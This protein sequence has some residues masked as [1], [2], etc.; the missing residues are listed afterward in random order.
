MY[1]NYFG[2]EEPPFSIAPN[3]RY[4]YLSKQHR[5]ALAHLLYGI[6]ND[7][8]FVLLTGEVGTGKTT[9][10]RALLDQLPESTDVALILNP[11]YS[12]QE[13][14]ASICDELGIIYP[15]EENRIKQYIDALNQHLLQSHAEG[16]HTVLILDEAQ[17]LGVDVLEQ[18]R[19][20][21]NLETD[22]H[23]LLQIVLVGQPELLEKLLRPELRQLSQ[24][25]TARFHLGALSR[26]ELEAYISHRLEVA[27]VQGRLFP[28][29]TLNRLYKMTRGVPRLI[30]ILCDRALLGAF[31]ERHNRVEVNVLNRAASEVLGED[32]ASV[33]D[34]LAGRWQF[35]G[36]TVVVLLLLSWL[37]VPGVKDQTLQWGGSL[38]GDSLLVQERE[39]TS[40]ATRQYAVLA[41]G[42]NDGAAVAGSVPS[43]LG[44]W[45]WPDRQEYQL[46]QIFAY[47]SLFEA[48][49]IEYNPKQNPVVCKFARS[50]GYA[51][52]FGS[53]ELESLIRLN[54][55]AVLKLVNEKGEDFFAALISIDGDRADIII[56]DR[57]LKVS[58]TELKRWW[59]H[60]YTVFWQMPPGYDGVIQPGNQSKNTLWLD[61]QLALIQGR[62]AGRRDSSV[63]DWALVKQVK[64]FQQSQGL[65]AD[66]IV[67]PKTSI[68]LNTATGQSVPLLLVP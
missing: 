19:L 67:G 23:K 25:I 68:H 31:V 55:P 16:R 38:F 33:S 24:R 41:S 60:V 17:N 12:S 20:L 5:E 13:L 62:G 11:K 52:L 39:G 26:S 27:G 51:C 36:L 64:Q 42:R 8:G 61:Q 47:R 10:C 63:Y 49:G 44:Q 57:K 53:G 7:G 54:R 37:F 4:L 14:L 18:I 2:L 1:S 50:M 28:A 66:G 22:C 45:S 58:L 34:W 32:T 65:M 48:W 21:T 15:Q 6:G 46:N 9:V 40:D 59:R 3:P 30:N 35:A 43:S 56:D 29:A